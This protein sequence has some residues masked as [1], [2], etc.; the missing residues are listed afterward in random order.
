[1]DVLNL[2]L[3]L[4]LFYHHFEGKRN[5]QTYKLLSRLII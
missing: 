4:K 3:S 5:V 1:L 2:N